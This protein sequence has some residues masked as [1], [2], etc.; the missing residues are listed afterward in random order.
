M[1]LDYSLQVRIL[2]SWGANGGLPHFR[3]SLQ[4]QELRV[5][6]GRGL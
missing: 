5:E 3:M 6:Q 4:K 1:G 2:F